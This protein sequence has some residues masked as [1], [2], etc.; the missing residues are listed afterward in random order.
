MFYK[1]N[2]VDSVGDTLWIL[3]STAFCNIVTLILQ[4]LLT[5]AFVYA[6]LTYIRSNPDTGCALVSVARD[7]MCPNNVIN[8]LT[9]T[10]TTGCNVY[11]SLRETLCPL[12]FRARWY[13]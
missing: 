9:L 11:T 2:A 7:V 4:I 8:T 1:K 10:P 5:V 12:Q 6:F 13:L 3:F